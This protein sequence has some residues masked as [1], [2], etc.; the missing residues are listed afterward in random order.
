[1]ACLAGLPFRVSAQSADQGTLAERAAR[2]NGDLHL[3]ID[4]DRRSVLPFRESIRSA[5]LVLR[6]IVN[7]Q[8]SR[9]TPDGRSIETDYTIATPQV[10]ISRS[11]PRPGDDPSAVP[12]VTF[13]MIGGTVRINGR[14]VSLRVQQVQPV[15]VGMELFVLLQAVGDGRMLVP[16][17]AGL[18]EIRLSTI[19]PLVR[20]P[21][22]HLNYAGQDSDVFL[23]DVLNW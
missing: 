14:A 3:T 4:L 16:L 20:W 11:P 17:G 22:E 6:G 23:N 19:V 1:M 21:G 8:H 2:S 15:V 12:P 13:T 18:F 10:F 7:D 5:D 9:M